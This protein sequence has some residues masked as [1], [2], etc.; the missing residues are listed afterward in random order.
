MAMKTTIPLIL[1]PLLA[2]APLPAQ[3]DPESPGRDL[4]EL[5][6]KMHRE[7]ATEA[8][9]RKLLQDRS[10]QTLIEPETPHEHQNPQPDRPGPE[11]PTWKIGLVVEPV[12]PFIR[13]HL[14][15]DKNEG[16]RVVHVADGSPAA[17]IGLEVNDIVLTAGDKR[18]SNLEDLKQVVERAGREGQQLKLG[19]IHKGERKG[20]QIRPEGPPPQAEGERGQ[21][22]RAGDQPQ[23]PAMMRRMDEMTRRMEK[24]QR[25]IEELRREVERLKR[26]ARADE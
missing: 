5:F 11:G 10:E 15:L 19:W 16:V 20:A 25:E 12:A 4:I 21:D 26:E 13:E 22:E 14:G 24:Q 3:S 17:R 23:R 7:G 1:L 8:D 6:D 18:I 9:L 2:A